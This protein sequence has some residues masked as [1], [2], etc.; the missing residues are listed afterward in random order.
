MIDFDFIRV[1]T[2]DK[3]LEFLQEK[4]SVTRLLAGGTDLLIELRGLNLD[5]PAAPR[6]ILDISG[7]EELKDIREANGS[8][9]IGPLTPHSKIAS[10]KLVKRYAPCLA[11]ACSTI[12]AVQHRTVG[13]IGGNIIN[14][15]PAADSVPALIV[16]DAEVTFKS[17]KGERSSLLK[18]IFIKPY[19]TNIQPDEL[20]TEIR[21]EKLPEGAKTSF[22]KLGRRNALAIARM[23]IA[24]V[25]ILKGKIVKDIR[26]S[27]G[28]TTPMPDRIRIA[29]EVL[30][31]KVPTKELILT[32][33]KKV[34]EEMIRRSGVRWSTPY[35][36]PVIEA[37]VARAL[38][39]ALGM[40]EGAIEN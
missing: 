17:A 5:D 23:N 35:K 39:Q 1:K 18:D 29:E 27:P 3:A 9:S 20:L 26:I 12:G 8:L 30:L 36:K 21:F 34:S 13:T 16:L 24:A 28:S 15:S 37:L 33:G 6:Y 40:E 31:G 7:I 2:L 4:G 25:V 32:A 11:Q 10:S 22:I 14:A 38:R 19:Q